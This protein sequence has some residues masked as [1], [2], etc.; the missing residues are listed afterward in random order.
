[1]KQIWLYVL[2]L[3]LSLAFSPTCACADTNDEMVGTIRYAVRLLGIRHNS[4]LD[5]Q[6]QKA[7]LS[8]GPAIGENYLNSYR[9]HLRPEEHTAENPCLHY[10]SWE[11]IAAQSLRDPEL[12]RPCLEYGCT[13]TV[14]LTA[15]SPL[16]EAGQSGLTGDGASALS[17][18]I[19]YSYLRWNREYN[20]EGGWPASRVR[21]TLNGKDERTDLTLAGEDCLTAA[22]CLFSCF[23]PELRERIVPAAVVT[24]L[25]YDTKDRSNCVVTYDRLFLLS[26]CEMHGSISRAKPGEGQHYE[27]LCL[28]PS[29]TGSLQREYRFFSESGDTVWAWL[30]S[31]SDRT[32]VMNYTILGPGHRVDGVIYNHYA[33]APAF[34]LP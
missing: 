10:M 11:E 19:G 1:M 30:R 27:A 12:L 7:G 22:N 28:Q 31:S 20:C 18:R 24:D 9:A 26:A 16:F 34:C 4:Y 17:H 32:D 15:R 14:V 8:F 6:G 29:K 5:D 3:L 23:P 21:A 2:L 13:H 25:S 33:L